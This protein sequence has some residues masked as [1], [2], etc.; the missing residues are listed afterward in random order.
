MTTRLASLIFLFSVFMLLTMP[1]RAQ[2][3]REIPREWIDPDTGHR[4]V[5]LSDGFTCST[6]K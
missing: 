1:I 5:R 4:V 6:R 2:G 3:E